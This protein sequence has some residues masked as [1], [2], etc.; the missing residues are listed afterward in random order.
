MSVLRSIEQKIE[1]LFEGMFGRA[2]RTHVQPVE[3]A[4]KL[5]KEMDE[6]R[7]I[8]VSRVY[9]PNEYSVYL[10]EADR[11]QFTGYEGSLIG[12]L[13]DYLVEHARR[14]SYALL[15]P[16]KV[17][18]LTDADLSIGEFGIATRVVQPEGKR[19]P[20]LDEPAAQVEPGATMIY[21]AKP[22]Q[23]TEAVSPAELGV[24]QESFSLTMNGRK[25][26][27]EGRQGRARALEGLRPAGR[28]RQRLATPR[29]A[30]QGGLVLVARRP[31]L[32]QRH[33]AERQARAADAA[34]RR[35]HDHPRRHRPRLRK[36]RAAVNIA[37]DE[38][39][40]ILKVGFIV[41]LYLFIWR[42]VRS[43]SRDFRTG[44]AAESVIMSPTDAAGLGLAPVVRAKLVVLKSPALDPG[45]EV[46]VD[47]LPVAVGRGGQN[48]VPLEGDDFASAQHARFESK[49]DGLW[50]EDIGSTNGTF[51][52]G[53][54][55]TT[56]RRL[57]KGDVVR[58]GQT[59]FRV[60]V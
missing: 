43:A 31:R 12:E 15:T 33:R 1:G 18:M 60:E 30:A 25:H 4:R 27:V 45:E 53:A 35:R 58:V 19:G 40:L 55:V 5:A 47:S 24:E 42:I 56:P 16:P 8:S 59:D 39:L 23:P 10:S 32:D 11:E 21:K 34:R 36:D 14:E 20:A 48:E 13:Q 46:P 9:V 2:F 44:P 17:L 49:R 29:R 26:A 37:V 7:T 51:V 28:G 52:N 57:S 22:P 3:L 6:H 38:A 54:R 41:L 50:V